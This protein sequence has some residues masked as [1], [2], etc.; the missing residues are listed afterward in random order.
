MTTVQDESLRWQPVHLR[1]MCAGD[2]SQ[3]EQRNVYCRAQQRFLSLDDCSSCQRF[4]GMDR[5]ERNVFIICRQPAAEER[6]EPLAPEHR[7]A[8]S[9]SP[10][11][12]VSVADIM[13]IDVVCVR[14][15]VSVET[16]TRILLERAISGVPVVSDQGV[17]VGV[18]SKTDVV[19]FLEDRMGSDGDT[20]VRV[21]GGDAYDLGP[22]FHVEEFAR[23]TASEVMSPL[24]FSIP[25]DASIAQAAAIMAF[26]GVH[27]LPVVSGAGEVVGLISAIDVMRWIGRQADYVIPDGTA[28]QMP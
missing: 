13:T 20:S 6:S 16:I 2:G 26:D 5:T 7:E 19:R 1:R 11:D 15:D 24:V 10:P 9:C 3:S 28:Q 14:P 17:P 22:G 27:R 18:V 12:C 4:F 23:A 21:P 8:R 25:A